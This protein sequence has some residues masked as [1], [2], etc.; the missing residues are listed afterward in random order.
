MDYFLG[1]DI[2]MDETHAC[3]LDRESAVVYPQLNQPIHSFEIVE[4]MFVRLGRPGMRRS[5]T[6][7]R[8]GRRA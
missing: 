1:L 3:V 7:T 8:P 2:S 5:F 4:T 6:R